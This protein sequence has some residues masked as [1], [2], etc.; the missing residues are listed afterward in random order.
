MR[1][2]SL[3]SWVQGG[4]EGGLVGAARAA[5]RLPLGRRLTERKQ[6]RG[7]LLLLLVLV[8]VAPLVLFVISDRMPWWRT[9][10]WQSVAYEYSG[11]GRAGMKDLT[12]QKGDVRYKAPPGYVVHKIFRKKWFWLPGPVMIWESGSGPPIRRDLKWS[13]CHR[14]RA[15]ISSPIR[16]PD[17]HRSER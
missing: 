8:S 17:S 2:F 4:S 5:E 7:R 11:G 14:W 1:A 12:I 13:C 3:L 6:F 16:T 9:E 10:G 15:P